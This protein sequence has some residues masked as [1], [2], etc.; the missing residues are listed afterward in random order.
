MLSNVTLFAP[1]NDAFKKLQMQDA[2]FTGL[3]SDPA[4][5]TGLLLYHA[6]PT[7]IKANMFNTT[8]QFV[9]TLLSVSGPGMATGLSAV[10]KISLQ[11]VGAAAMV[12][13]G[14]KQMSMITKYDQVFDGGVVHIIDTVLT[15]PGTPSDTALDLGLTS[16]YGALN[17]TSMLDDVNTLQ[18]A[19]IFAPNNL[20]FEAVGSV[21]NSASV[22]D[23]MSVLGYH[24]VQGTSMPGMPM[25]ST[26]LMG[27][28]PGTAGMSMAAK[29]QEQTTMT[30]ATF[31]GGN[32]TVGVDADTGDLFINS[33][34]V[35]MSDII[36]SNGVIHVLDK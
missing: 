17:K 29:R 22:A 19:T 9:P 1:S 2:N 12:F 5:I 7:V 28:M 3:V 20:A 25:F 16:F 11:L 31:A 35:V 6:V 26:M 18:D 27:M 10:Q 4:F 8:P 15:P 13:S 32:V 14:F 23:L 21:V 30:L 24:V 33:A 34:K 36:T